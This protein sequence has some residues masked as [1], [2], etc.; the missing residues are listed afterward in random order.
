MQI[1]TRRFITFTGLGS[2][3]LLLRSRAFAMDIMERIVTTQTQSIRRE[4]T[5]Y[6][7]KIALAHAHNYMVAQLHTKEAPTASTTGKPKSSPERQALKKKLPHYVAVDTPKDKRS[8]PGTKTDIMIWDTQS[9]SLVG[10]DVY[11]VEN[12][13]KL[14][15]TAKFETY[16]AQY[17]G[18]GN[19]NGF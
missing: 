4:A 17:V 13:P 12:P 14:G 11:D 3:F 15:S 6:Q 16:S 7:R 9:E 18:S 10:N 5:E 1:S 19:G 8:V 2:A